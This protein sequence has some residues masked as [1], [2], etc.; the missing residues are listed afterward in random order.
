MRCY[1]CGAEVLILTVEPR[2][3][4]ETQVFYL[5]TFEC[6]NCGLAENRLT[7]HREEPSLISSTNTAAPAKPDRYAPRQTSVTEQ[8]AF[9]TKV[10][11]VLK[12][13]Q[14]KPPKPTVVAPVIPESTAPVPVDK[15]SIPGPPLP[16]AEDTAP[17]FAAKTPSIFASINACFELRPPLE[18]VESPPPPEPPLPEPPP[19]P[20]IDS[21]AST[22]RIM[23]EIAGI[24]SRVPHAPAK[25]RAVAPKVPIAPA[26]RPS[27]A[28]PMLFTPVE[29]DPI[30]D[31]KDKERLRELFRKVKVEIRRE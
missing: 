6:R 25:R 2:R 13:R 20:E 15:I 23:E 29:F 21:I 19:S 8:V 14:S 16:A 31:D 3:L 18:A 10:E 11:E 5:H 27:I 12:K 7:P 17:V 28:A 26:Q 22:L 24:A 4:S 30:D 1:S 9:G